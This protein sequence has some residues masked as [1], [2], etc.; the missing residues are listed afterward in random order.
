MRSRL[1]WGLA[2]AGLAVLVVTGSVMLWPRPDPNAAVEAHYDG[3]PTSWWAARCQDGK[4]DEQMFPG[5]YDFYGVWQYLPTGKMNEQ[6]RDERYLQC[7]HLLRGEAE[8]VPVL[9]E[10]LQDRNW[11]VRQAAIYGLCAAYQRDKSPEA[12]AALTA[13]LRDYD[14]DVRTLAATVLRE[15]DPEG[16][17]KA[18]IPA[19]DEAVSREYHAEFLARLERDRPKMQR[20]VLKLKI[21]L[22]TVVAF[23]VLLVWWIKRRR[24]R[25]FPGK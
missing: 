5:K 22:A 8:A 6:T 9:L 18:G 21:V 10:L 2:L 16:A 13:A 11:H 25:W 24:H 7:K 1:R 12:H 19:N 23:L 17:A 20:E 14:L 3:K 4:L 15:S